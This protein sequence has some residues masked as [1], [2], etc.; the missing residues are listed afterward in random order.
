MSKAAIVL[1]PLIVVRQCS[2]A[3]LTL[4]Q[5]LVLACYKVDVD[6]AVKC[7]RKGAQVNSTIGDHT[8][9]RD[10]FRDRWTGAGQHLGA[11]AWTPLLALAAS[12]TYPDPPPEF[13]EIWKDARRVR[14]LRSKVP[15]DLIAR[16]EQE[17]MNILQILLSHGCNLDD[18]DGYGATAVYYAAD[19]DKLAMAKVL[20]AYG[21]NPNTKTGVYIDG[22]SDKSP[23]HA[24]CRS[25]AMV[26]LLLDHGADASVKDSDGRTPADW[27]ALD[28]ERQFDLVA[29]GSGWTTVLRVKTQPIEKRR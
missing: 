3:D 10:V 17:A 20:L 21:A 29:T 14:A 11:S 24:A 28:D 22:P 1:L 2:G 9:E 8:N 16:R 4:D 19:N 12:P 7:L 25:R 13:G 15:R 23:L 26:Q 18:H 5:R 27:V 6:G